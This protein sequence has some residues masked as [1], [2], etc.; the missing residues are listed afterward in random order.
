MYV[1]GFTKDLA[2]GITDDVVNSSS[3]KS[4]WI[5]KQNQNRHHQVLHSHG[6]AAQ[7]RDNT[8]YAVVIHTHTETDCV[9]STIASSS[10]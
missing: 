4:N 1:F 3:S 7:H 9:S 2:E 10:S 5:T 6:P 8:L